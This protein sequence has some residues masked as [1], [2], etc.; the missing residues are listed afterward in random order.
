[1]SNKTVLT[2]EEVKAIINATTCLRDRAL[3]YLLADTGIRCSEA[4]AIK[5]NDIDYENNTIMIPH[6]KIGVKKTCCGCGRQ[7]GGK[8][9]FCVKCGADISDVKSE[10]EEKRTRIV[11][12]GNVAMNNI[13]EYV[14]ARK[15]IKRYETD[16]L[17]P[18][19]RVTVNDIVKQAAIKAGLS[20]K[21]LTNPETGRKHFVSPHK[22]RDALAV[23]WLSSSFDD[24]TEA[25]KQKALQMH[26]GHKR[27]ET[28]A[29]YQKLSEKSISNVSSKVRKNRLGD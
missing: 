25:D 7:A 15:G 13:Q 17:F 19:K 26:L 5:L 10:G 9:A 8:Q 27:Y 12:V 1:M 18:I 29:R 16:L 6:L 11:N 23:D 2:I 22:F 4:L 24:V 21:I 14:K 20:G 3:V 28:T